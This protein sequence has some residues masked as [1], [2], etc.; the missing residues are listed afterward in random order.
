MD[1]SEVLPIKRLRLCDTVDICSL[2]A[3][4]VNPAQ[5][6]SIKPDAF[7]ATALR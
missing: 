4:V 5:S 3:R 2:Q 1:V 6:A 7:S